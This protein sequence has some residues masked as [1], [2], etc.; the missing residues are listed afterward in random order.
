MNVQHN[1]LVQ[2]LGAHFPAS[3]PVPDVLAHDPER[4]KYVLDLCTGTGIWY[5]GVSSLSH[6]LIKPRTM[7]MA[8]QFPHVAFR[9][10]DIGM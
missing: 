1:A 8:E 6:T 3:C 7:E 9:A 5:A 10:I 4:Q 2:L